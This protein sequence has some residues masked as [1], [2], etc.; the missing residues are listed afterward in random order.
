[1]VSSSIINPQ[2]VDYQVRDVDDHDTRTPITRKTAE[3]VRRM[4]AASSDEREC[5]L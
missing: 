3:A 4:V 5:L 1:M 2:R